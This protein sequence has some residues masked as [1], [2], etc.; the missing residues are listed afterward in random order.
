MTSMPPPDASD[1]PD[2]PPVVRQVFVDTQGWAEIFHSLALH[3]AAAV[4]FV[5]QAQAGRWELITSNLILSELVP[6][7]HSRNFRLTQPQILDMITRVRNLPDLIVVY[8]DM[9]IDRQA[10][11]LLAANP[12]HPWSHV[13]ATSMALMRQLG[14]T[15]ILTA[16]KHFAQ[17]GFVVLL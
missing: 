14:V 11:A 3:H 17:A 10:W 1:P 2:A 8:V 6:L 5:Q 12:Q 16:D 15:E 9:A 4:A 13:D 7:L